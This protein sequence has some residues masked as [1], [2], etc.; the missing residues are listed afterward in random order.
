M[1]TQKSTGRDLSRDIREVLSKHSIP[2][3]AIYDD[4]V[5]AA[6]ASRYGMNVRAVQGLRYITECQ[7][8][9]EAARHFAQLR[10]WCIDVDSGRVLDADGG[11]LA[12]NLE[13]LT[14]ALCRQSFIIDESTIWSTSWSVNNASISDREIVDCVRTYVLARFAA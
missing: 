10:G 7:S 1:A 3:G 6:L 5:N 12:G 11:E 9:G 2:V 14:E 8:A 4:L 13:E